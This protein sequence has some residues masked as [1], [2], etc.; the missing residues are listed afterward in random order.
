MESEKNIC[1]HQ[2]RLLASKLRNEN[3]PVHV[4]LLNEYLYFKQTIKNHIFCSGICQCCQEKLED[5]KFGKPEENLSVYFHGLINQELNTSTSGDEGEMIKK[6]KLQ[7]LLLFLQ[8]EGPFQVVIDGLNVAMHP[9]HGLHFDPVNKY[10]IKQS[11]CQAN[12][13]TKQQ[14]IFF[15]TSCS[16]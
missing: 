9:R 15:T 4:I 7:E 16:K 14:F 6:D 5:V 10:K 11:T 1:V 12:K 8:R 3:T 2:V 13:L